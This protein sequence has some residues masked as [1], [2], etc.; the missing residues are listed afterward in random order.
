M[1]G[2]SREEWL[3]AVGAAHVT[4]DPDALTVNELAVVFGL[5][6]RATQ[7]RIHQLTAQGRLTRHRKRVQNVAG[8]WQP[9]TAYKLAPAKKR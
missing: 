6:R 4:E 2:I 1:T 7:D 3:A 9:V 5:S 8:Q